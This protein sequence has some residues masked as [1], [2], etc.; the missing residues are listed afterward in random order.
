MLVVLAFWLLENPGRLLSN[1]AVETLV[2][3]ELGNALKSE[4]SELML[5][6]LLC[7]V[8]LPGFAP[9]DA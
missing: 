2:D 5:V 3:D 4:E 9:S 1:D 8:E 7:A 6:E